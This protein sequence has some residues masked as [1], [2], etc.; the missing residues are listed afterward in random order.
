MAGPREILDMPLFAVKERLA[1]VNFD[2]RVRS[3]VSR[4]IRETGLSRKEV[5]QRM[6][7]MLGVRITEGMINAWCA[8]SK[9][10]RFPAAYIPALAVITEDS[11]LIEEMA[12][13]CGVYVIT[14]K[15]L[16][17]LKLA[18][19]REEKRRLKDLEKELLK[20]LEVQK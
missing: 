17:M 11:S 8:E 16:V 3:W 1:E 9:G 5:A 4:A 20:L 15:Q 6:S 13:F 18:E 19:V 10:H 12:E 7:A 14:R 2:G